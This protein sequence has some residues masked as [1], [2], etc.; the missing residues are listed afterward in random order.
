VV[1]VGWH[2]APRLHSFSYKGYRA[3]FVTCCTF[4]RRA[5]F[6]DAQY[7]EPITE[8]LLQSAATCQ[9]DVSAYCFM[10]EHMHVLV[11]GTTDSSDF[12]RLMNDFKQRTAYARKQASG[13]RLWQQ[14]YYDRVLRPEDDRLRVIA[15]LLENP[16]RRGLVHDLRDYPFWGSGV[17]TREQLLES[18]EHLTGGAGDRRA[19]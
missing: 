15:Y 5:C 4:R 3:Y 18:I 9:F 12:C 8:Q 13:N 19:G 10:P 16:L 17:W 6:V 14:G 2:A 1:G 11:D 7:V